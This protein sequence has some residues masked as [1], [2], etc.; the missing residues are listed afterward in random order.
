MIP[1]LGTFS[2]ILALL[3]AIVQGTFPLL[4]ARRTHYH[5]MNLARSAAW[6]QLVC[7]ISMFFVSKHLIER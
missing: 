6:S 3:C 7:S 5:W 4:G 1:E 2:L